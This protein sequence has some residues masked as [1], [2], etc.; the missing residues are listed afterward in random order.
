MHVI[1]TMS[2]YEKFPRIVGTTSRHRE[3]V[4]F[5]L[6]KI[7]RTSEY[8]STNMYQHFLLTKFPRIVGTTWRYWEIVACDLL[9]IWRTSEYLSTNMYQ[10]LL[11]TLSSHKM[12]M[13][14]SQ[15]NIVKAIHF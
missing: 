9:K 7:W 13:N 10:H 6:L 8:L 2:S 11:L 3:M 4:A 15:E 12:C 5:D 1:R 14:F